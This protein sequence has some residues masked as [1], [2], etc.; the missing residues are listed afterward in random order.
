MRNN[1]LLW[2]VAIGLLVWAA[3]KLGTSFGQ[4]RT[5]Q[6]SL[7]NDF[8]GHRDETRLRLSSLEAE[9]ATRERRWSFAKKAVALG[10]KLPVIR[11]FN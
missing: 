6:C 9:R 2:L 8:D 4:M 7:R 11:W 1:Q 3:F 10:K 5:E